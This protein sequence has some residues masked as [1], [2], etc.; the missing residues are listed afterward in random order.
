MQVAFFCGPPR[1][2]LCDIQKRMRMY[3]IAALYKNHTCTV[4]A[5]AAAL[6]VIYLHTPVRRERASHRY[7]NSHALVGID[8]V[9]QVPST[10]EQV[11]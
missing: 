10:L 6:R 7:R 3:I 9:V 1:Q 2:S 4:C 11:L 5:A 8:A